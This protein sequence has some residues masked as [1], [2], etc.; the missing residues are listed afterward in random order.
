MQ[1]I[2][3]LGARI[4]V[5]H[6]VNRRKMASGLFLGWE[7]RGNVHGAQWVYVVAQGPECKMK[8]ASG[9]KALLEDS[10]VL[11]PEGLDIWEDYKALPEFSELARLQKETDCDIETRPVLERCLIALDD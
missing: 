8:L 10:L 7:W 2:R 9:T 11:D 3:P 1:K 4:I 5:F 6:P